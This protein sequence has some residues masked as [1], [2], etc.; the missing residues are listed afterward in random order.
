MKKFKKIFTAATASILCL[1]SLT[2]LSGNAVFWTGIPNNEEQALEMIKERLFYNSVE[3]FVPDTSGMF[4]NG[5]R[6]V[7]FT[8]NR[9]MCSIEAYEQVMKF[10]MTPAAYITD[11][12]IETVESFLNELYPDVYFNVKMDG[13]SQFSIY[14][15]D[16]LPF[17][18]RLDTAE[19][20][21]V[22]YNFVAE[23]FPVESC[24]F[25]G[26]YVIPERGD[27]TGFHCTDDERLASLP[28]YYSTET[29][30]ILQN[31]I[32]EKGLDVELKVDNP[33]GDN[34]YPCSVITDG[35]T[36]QEVAQLYT[37]IYNDLG[38]KPQVWYQ[39][40]MTSVAEPLNLCKIDGDANTDDELT[41]ADATLIMQFLTNKDEY[42]LT[43]QG[44]YNADLDKDGITAADALVIQKMV[45]EKGE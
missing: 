16:A 2:A 36:V 35:M 12:D 22:V 37:D 15:S 30:A 21:E 11:E 31:Y 28:G 18:G 5:D 34:S 29:P 20:A 19:D 26:G 9:G 40:S 8:D 25:Y 39:V 45:A 23:R 32:D 10:T 6:I 17:D 44:V 42:D 3:N 27:M 4:S 13:K 1:S 38:L 41:I 24:E 7:Y 33:Y 43:E 14:D